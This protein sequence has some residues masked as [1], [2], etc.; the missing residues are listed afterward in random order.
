MCVCACTQNAPTLCCMFFKRC[1][2]NTP[3]PHRLPDGQLSAPYSPSPSLS[4]FGAASVMF[5]CCLPASLTTTSTPSVH[6]PVNSLVVHTR[7][8]YNIG[9]HLNVH[10]MFDQ[11]GIVLESA[12]RRTSLDASPKTVSLITDTRPNSTTNCWPLAPSGYAPAPH[13][14]DR[15]FRVANPPCIPPLPTFLP[16]TLVSPLV[17]LLPYCLV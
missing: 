13:P 11:P 15:C 2:T 5:C 3:R 6:Y 16:L 9:D 10:N 7:Y 14:L 4:S 8:L 1:P 12:R 17:L